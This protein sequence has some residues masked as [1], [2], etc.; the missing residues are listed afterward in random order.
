MMSI[1]CYT[2]WKTVSFHWFTNR[3]K[4]IRFVTHGCTEPCLVKTPNTL[5]L[6]RYQSKSQP[7]MIFKFLLEN[8]G[9]DQ[10]KFMRHDVYRLPLMSQENTTR[11]KHYWDSASRPGN[12]QDLAH[13]AGFWTSICFAHSKRRSSSSS[14]TSGTDCRRSQQMWLPWLPWKLPR[15]SISSRTSCP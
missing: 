10:P 14:A 1:V 6:L 7:N 12:W 2:L 15:R 11:M 3:I 4:W 8:C 9:S 13:N 5:P